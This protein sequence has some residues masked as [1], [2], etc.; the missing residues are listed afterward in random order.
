MTTENEYNYDLFGVLDILKS[1]GEATQAEIENYPSSNADRFKELQ[2]LEYIAIN[3]DDQNVKKE[4]YS[5]TEKGIDAWNT[6]KTYGDT[7]H[8]QYQLTRNEFMILQALSMN[9]PMTVAELVRSMNIDAL[10]GGTRLRHIELVVIT[11]REER[12]SIFWEISGEQ[13]EEIRKSLAVRTEDDY[14]R[15]IA[16]QLAESPTMKAFRS[17]FNGDPIDE[18]EDDKNKELVAGN[19]IIVFEIP[20]N[21]KSEQHPWLNYMKDLLENFEDRDEIVGISVHKPTYQQLPRVWGAD[22]PVGMFGPKQGSDVGISVEYR[23]LLGLPVKN[24]VIEWGLS[25][26]VRGSVIPESVDDVIKIHLLSVLESKDRVVDVITLIDPYPS[27]LV[28]PETFYPRGMVDSFT[29]TGVFD[30]TAKQIQSSTRSCL[31]RGQ[32]LYDALKKK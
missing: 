25:Y 8:S 19:L 30:I 5:L 1:F 32:A 29:D 6:K 22:S 17:S 28:P 14:Y 9:G 23:E 12:N 31:E 10:N 24:G 7:L 13:L 26:S 11:T 3:V 21:I 2:A 27:K 20:E 15:Q 4:T 18:P 16:L